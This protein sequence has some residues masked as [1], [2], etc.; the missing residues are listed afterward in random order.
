MPKEVIVEWVNANKGFV[1]LQSRVVILPK[2]CLAGQ[3]NNELSNLTSIKLE[4]LLDVS[5]ISNI[6]RIP[7]ESK[8]YTVSPEFNP[9]IIVTE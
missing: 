2:R 3:E 1:R 8:A 6:S 9:K 4:N 5:N 7:K